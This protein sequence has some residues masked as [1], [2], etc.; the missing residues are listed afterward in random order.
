MDPSG[1]DPIL[2]VLGPI[3]PGNL[4]SKEELEN[5]WTVIRDDI[6]PGAG[7][8]LSGAWTAMIRNGGEFLE[9][10]MAGKDT[11]YD[12][13][14]GRKTSYEENLE[15]VRRTRKTYVEKRQEEAGNLTLFY[16]GNCIG[17]VATIFTFLKVGQRSSST[18][19]S[20]GAA[21]TVLKGKMVTVEG[22]EVE[23]EIEGSEALA[24]VMGLPSDNPSGMEEDLR[25]LWESINGIRKIQKSGKRWSGEDQGRHWES[26]WKGSGNDE[27]LGDANIKDLDKLPKNKIME[28]GGEDYT[29]GIKRNTGKSKSD[30]YWDKEGNVYSVP[31]KGGAPQWIDWIPRD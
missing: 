15:R 25:N 20:A 16:I 18:D 9:G 24:G 23:V 27:D 7:D 13:A 21:S 17:D 10:A 4:P 31:K 1:N 26:K 12:F 3:L 5:T 2:P 14:I 19:G 8:I 29:Q 11:I 28:L 22:I 30:L 6:I